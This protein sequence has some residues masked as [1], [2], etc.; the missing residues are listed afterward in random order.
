MDKVPPA[1]E[2]AI[3]ADLRPVKRLPPPHHRVLWLAP[4]ALATLVAAQRIFSMRADAPVLGW[5]LTWGLSALQTVLALALVALALRHATPGRSLHGRALAATLA[6][7]AGLLILITVRTWTVSPTTLGPYS[8]LIVGQICFIGTLV[9]ALPLLVGS[10]VLA[11]R[12][13]SVRSWSSGALYGLGAGLGA[14]AGWRLFCHFSDP[15]HVFP[16]HTGAVLVV[17][18]LGMVISG[19]SFRLKKPISGK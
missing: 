3:T 13:F 8:P 4:L 14:D 12:V 11:L 19:V 5:A 10:A 18:V 15:A 7:V 2:A 6:M 17:T 1:L 9:A 16:T